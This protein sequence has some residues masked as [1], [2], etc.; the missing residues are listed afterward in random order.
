M[1]KNHAKRKELKGFQEEEQEDNKENVFSGSREKGMFRDPLHVVV[2]RQK[3][4]QVQE[5]RNVGYHKE[6]PHD[7]QNM[8]HLKLSSSVF[9][10]GADSLDWLRDCEEYFDI[11]KVAD[12][13]RAVIATMHLSGAPR[14]RYKI[15]Y[16]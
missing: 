4:L 2:E 9:K 10:E 13:R 3:Q 8:K 12:R 7:N 5:T 14:S 15:F 11:Y 16:N 6:I 1:N